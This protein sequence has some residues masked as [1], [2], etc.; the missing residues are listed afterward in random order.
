MSGGRRG[1]LSEVFSRENLAKY[2]QY[3]RMYGFKSATRFAIQRLKKPIGPPPYTPTPVRLPLL[4]EPSATKRAGRSV[5]VVIPTR[6]AGEQFRLLLKKLR[7]QEGLAWLEIIV[8]DSGS[9]DSTLQI[10]QQEQAKI[11]TIAPEEFTHA[12]SRNQGSEAAT[13]D[14]LL[15]LVQDALPLT[16]SWLV[17][18]VSFLEA[19]DAAAVSCAE[20]PRADSDLF[21]QYLIY[22][23]HN[24]GKLNCDRVTDISRVGSSYIDSRS[25][26]H[27]TDIAALIRRDVFRQFKYRTAYAEDLDLG[28]R[29]IQGNHRLGFLYSTRVLH[30]HNRPAVYFLKRGYVDVRFLTQVFPNYVYP[31]IDDQERMYREIVSLHRQ[32]GQIRTAAS[33]TGYP[34]TIDELTKRLRS[35]DSDKRANGACEI[36]PEMRDFLKLIP[37]KAVDSNVSER[38]MVWLHVAKHLE[39]FTAWV[40]SVYREADRDLAREIVDAWGKIFALHCGTHLGYLFMTRAA[41]GDLDESLRHIDTWLTA[42]V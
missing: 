31:E 36:D 30:S 22:A 7:A 13:G 19:H 26:A 5:S 37:V 20:F 38:P 8:A 25:A 41:R 24:D 17:E 21:Y 39:Q 34:V 15:F 42:G 18:M 12:Y 4:S 6:N 9:S 10:A 27:L 28:V 23:Q 3:C 29:L 14:Y 2:R 16:N 32:F 40:S 1:I 35:A 11:V 33:S